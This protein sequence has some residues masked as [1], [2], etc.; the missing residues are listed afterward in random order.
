MFSDV[1]Q[2][3]SNGMHK[4]IEHRAVINADKAR[5]SIATFLL[6]DDEAE[7]SPA[8]SVMQDRS[9]MYRK[10]KQLDYVRQLLGT[11]IDGKFDINFLKLENKA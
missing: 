3:W 8:E 7:I 9:R 11:K 10:V 5:M 6:T 2:V 4:S 1:F